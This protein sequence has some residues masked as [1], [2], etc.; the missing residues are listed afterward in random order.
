MIQASTILIVHDDREMLGRLVAQLGPTADVSTATNFDEAKALLSVAPPTILITSVRLGQYNGLHLIIRSRIDYPA[1]AA[2]LIS[3][4]SDATLE[5]EAVKYGAT[6]LL[7][8]DQEKE[9]LSKV[10]LALA[11]LRGV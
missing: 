10:T 4:G 9:L 7:Y 11:R 3:E 5:A 6:F 8:P 2:F 1:T